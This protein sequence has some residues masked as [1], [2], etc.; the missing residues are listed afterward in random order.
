VSW[1]SALFHFLRTGN[2]TPPAAA[3]PQTATSAGHKV[4]ASNF[5]DDADLRGYWAAKKRG[6][7]DK[8]AF[9][10]GDNCLGFWGASTNSTTPMCALPPEDIEARWGNLSL[11]K[12]REVL[13]TVGKRS[14]ICLLADIMPRKR[15]ITNGCGIDL[16]PGAV[17][18]L[19]LK[20]PLK[21]PAVW[22]WASI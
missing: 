3:A 16:N 18:A 8:Q 2:V 20:T 11:G 13:V 15:N 1:L 7:T 22:R 12:N 5:A 10:F 6:L 21:T 9:K 19:G 4:L 17:T 14:V